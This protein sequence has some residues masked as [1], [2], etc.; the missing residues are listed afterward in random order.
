MPPFPSMTEETPPRQGTEAVEGVTSGTTTI[1]PAV[2]R[3]A[4][5]KTTTDEAA[6]G[7]MVETMEEEAMA[8]EATV[9]EANMGKLRQGRPWQRLRWRRPQRMHV[10]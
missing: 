8:R 9:D 4:M 6:V 3:V 7:S 2:V 1:E 5:E 10:R